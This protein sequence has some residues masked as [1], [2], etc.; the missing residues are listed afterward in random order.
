MEAGGGVATRAFAEL[1]GSRASFRGGPLGASTG[2]VAAAAS[3][4]SERG[5]AAIGSASVGGASATVRSDTGGVADAVSRGGSA[6]VRSATLASASDSRAKDATGGEVLGWRTTSCVGRSNGK[7]NAAISSRAR[8]ASGCCGSPTNDGAAIAASE[9]NA[10]DTGSARR[11]KRRVARCGARCTS[12]RGARARPLRVTAVIAVSVAAGDAVCRGG[13]IA[14]G[15][16]YGMTGSRLT[17][18]LLIEGRRRKA[19][20]GVVTMCIGGGMGAAGLFEIVH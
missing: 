8:S 19:K 11:E 18:H 9:A 3:F 14:I 2:F 20:Y 6:L 13:S 7:R 16:P 4:G 10:I 12:S 5:A 17:G 1:D 15:H